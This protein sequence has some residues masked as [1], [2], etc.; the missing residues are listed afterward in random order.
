M[1]PYE[2]SRASGRRFRD[3]RQRY[4]PCTSVASPLNS[5]HSVTLPVRT[6]CV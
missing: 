1:A 4:C 3:G 2:L 6:A 5:V